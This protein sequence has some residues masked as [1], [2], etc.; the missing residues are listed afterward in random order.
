MNRHYLTA[1]LSAILLFTG[2][3]KIS[4]TPPELNYIY[5]DTTAAETAASSQT[6]AVTEET[7]ITD[8]AAE[9]TV[10]VISAAAAVSDGVPST[11][12]D[13][14][15]YDNC[16]FFGDSIC[17][18]LSVYNDLV[19][20]E[21][22]AAVGGGAA[23]N[24]NEFTF[25]L[26]DIDYTVTTAAEA[27]Q[28]DIAFLWMGVNDINMTDKQTYAANLEGLAREINEVSPDSRIIIIGMTPTA[29]YHEWGANPTIIEYNAAAEEMVSSSELPLYYIDV[30]DVVSDE[31]GY[32]LTECD[33]GDGMHLTQL[34]YY[35]ILSKIN[36]EFKDL[37]PS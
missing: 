20:P 19:D 27:Y 12:W 16:L 4:E 10:T 28:P 14:A 17:R 32:L 1:A 26:H 33:G 34:A 3:E 21:R 36:T 8:A 35:R 7:V 2:C 24:L 13:P 30:G 15:F 22:V 18:A 9:E 31:N 6:E 29:A 23:R 37:I 25:K 11:E 5:Y